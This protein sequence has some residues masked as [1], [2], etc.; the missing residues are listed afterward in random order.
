CVVAS[1]DSWKELFISLSIFTVSTICC[2]ILG[3]AFPY[4]KNNPSSQI[5]LIFLGTVGLFPISYLINKFSVFSFS[6]QLFLIVL[7]LLIGILVTIS[8]INFRWEKE[9]L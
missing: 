2:F 9:S 8:I 5:S 4:N 1:L 3:I 6:M 7:L